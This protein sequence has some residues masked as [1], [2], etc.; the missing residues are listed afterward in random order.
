MTAAKT[1][2]GVLNAVGMSGLTGPQLL[3]EAGRVAVGEFLI[4]VRK[5]ARTLGRVAA[6]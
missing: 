3:T 4:D 6:A 5:L 2:L 1:A